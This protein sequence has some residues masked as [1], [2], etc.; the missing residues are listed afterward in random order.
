[1]LIGKAAAVEFGRS[2]AL[3]KCK[4]VVALYW[5]LVRRDVWSF[6]SKL[7]I[8]EVVIL[9]FVPTDTGLDEEL[10]REG[11]LL[12]VSVGLFRGLVV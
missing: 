4:V 6:D 10:D 9:T 7:F 5:R 12:Y 11:V 3:D 8:T 1:M 2:R